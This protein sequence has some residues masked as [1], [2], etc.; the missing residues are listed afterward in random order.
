[1]SSISTLS[2]EPGQRR[3][4]SL[5]MIP[6]QAQ[7]TGLSIDTLRASPQAPYTFGHRSPADANT[8]TSTNHA[9]TPSSPMS[10]TLGSP[11][12]IARHPGPWGE[13][14]PSRR[15]SVPSGTNPF[16][17]HG[18]VH[19]PM[20][21][22]LHPTNS[23]LQVAPPS[24][25]PSNPSLHSSNN[26]SLATS[27][28]SSVYTFGKDTAAAE[29]EW[30]RRTW[31]SYNQYQYPRPATSGL[32]FSQTPDAP[33]PAFAPLAV[34]AAGQ[35]Q[36]RLPGFETFDQI[37]KRPET[38]T[39]PGTND[40]SQPVTPQ[41]PGL[42]STGSDRSIPGPG[43]RRGHA[44]WDLSLHQNLTKLD[45][46]NGTPPKEPFMWPRP[47]VAP[48]QPTSQPLPTQPPPVAHSTMQSTT[49]QPPRAPNQVPSDASRIGQAN[50]TP[51]GQPQ[52]QPKAQ[53]HTPAR[54]K[55]NGW[56]HGPLA[57][58]QPHAPAPLQAPMHAI[59]QRRS[60]EDSSSSDGVHTPSSASM[61]YQPTNIVHANG[62]VE[63]QPAPTKPITVC[64][65]FRQ[66]MHLFPF[67]E[68]T[69]FRASSDL[70]CLELLTP[71]PLPQH[72]S[73]L[74]AR[75]SCDSCTAKVRPTRAR[76]TRRGSRERGQGCRPHAAA[77]I[78]PSPRR[79]SSGAFTLSLLS[80]P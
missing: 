25:H 32:T 69:S 66:Q 68:A 41:R 18:A 40:S 39:R 10:S 67:T 35:P 79:L 75:E 70:S 1:M 57:S 15:L 60:P 42:A 36:Q 80:R 47:D 76:R 28:T 48:F 51:Q 31:H 19:G 49:P 58:A 63:T 7:R 74:A 23:S 34:A 38:P 44:S 37:S 24:L 53:P 56:Y 12:S 64:P 6:P 14:P 9:H 61:D 78:R 73:Y 20:H 59:G 30:R 71:F 77:L 16:L 26:S 33:R 4:H 45:I 46:A 22:P 62:Y 65:S 5:T 2:Q 50:G 8:P 13:R 3:P 21:N 27:P 52:G 29:A 55:R 54:A 43:D 11:V 17:A 72:Q